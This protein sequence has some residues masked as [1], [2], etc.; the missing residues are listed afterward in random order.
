MALQVI[1]VAQLDHHSASAVELGR[2]LGMSQGVTVFPCDF[3][4]QVAFSY[5]K[6]IAL[7]DRR[8]THASACPV[9]M[10]SLKVQLHRNEA[11]DSL[12]QQYRVV[13]NSVDKGAFQ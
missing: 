13:C 5:F 12:P 8:R 11:D 9:C 2:L 1:Y 3:Y 7:H 4:S 6:G 10:P